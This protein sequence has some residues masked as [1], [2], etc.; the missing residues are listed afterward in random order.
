MPGVLLIAHTRPRITAMRLVPFVLVAALATPAWAQS[1][2]RAAA[3]AQAAPPPPSQPVLFGAPPAAA[4][5][6]ESID[7]IVAA[8]YDVIS[9]PVGQ[10]RDW[11]RMRSLFVPTARMMPV[12]VRKDGNVVMRML[13]VNDYVASSGD[14]L[15]QK[16][17]HEREL[18]RH[19]EQFGHIA[20][21][22]STFEGKLDAGP[23]VMRGINTLE[24]MNDGRRWWIVSIMWEDERPGLSLPAK[25]LPATAAGGG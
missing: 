11:N 12:G 21:V 3:A 25:Y 10:A 16:G 9:G 23:E 17:F 22:F 19:T 18:A 5:D 8:L 13:A 20:Q 15:V 4:K 24:L 1:D 7:A 6:V 2:P 14:L